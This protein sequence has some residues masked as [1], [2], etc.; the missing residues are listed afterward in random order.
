[1]A[2]KNYRVNDPIQV[3]YRAKKS[4]TGLTVLMDVLDETGAIDA[5]LSVAVMP[6]PNGDGVYVAS[7]TPDAQGEWMVYVYESGKADD[8]VIREY[9][10]GGYDLDTVGQAVDSIVADTGSPPMIG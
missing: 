4:G 1:M 6:E 10:V 5:V 2:E 3:E 8:K 7:F 9:S